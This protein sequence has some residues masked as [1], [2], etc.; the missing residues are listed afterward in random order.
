MSTRHIFHEGEH[1]RYRVVRDSSLR[2]A[3][4]KKSIGGLSRW[5]DLL[6]NPIPC[7]FHQESHGGK[8]ERILKSCLLISMYA[9]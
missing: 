8:T 3:R 5:F 4:V 7:L 2:E 6:Q 1:I 9:L